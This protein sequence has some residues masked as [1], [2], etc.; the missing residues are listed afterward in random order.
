MS[1]YIF[2]LA[3]YNGFKY[4]SNTLISKSK[5]CIF[6]YIWFF[7]YSIISLAGDNILLIYIFIVQE[8]KITYPKAEYR[9]LSISN[10]FSLLL[11]INQKYN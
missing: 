5:Y 7:N 10:Y 4:I 8:S 1:R 9:I 11:V 2:A 3:F 6:P